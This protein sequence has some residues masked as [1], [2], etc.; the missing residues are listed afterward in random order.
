MGDT[1]LREVSIHKVPQQEVEELHLV[2]PARVLVLH[3]TLL[4]L[5]QAIPDLHLELMAPFLGFHGSL[6]I[7]SYSTHHLMVTFMGLGHIDPISRPG[8][9]LSKGGAGV[10][11]RL[12]VFCVPKTE[13][14]VQSWII[15]NL[16]CR[17][18]G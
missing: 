12:C 10:I 6:R 7:L 18:H 15:E 17:G 1:G 9:A 5:P 14:A 11:F 16:S 3:P 8:G 2:C 4:T 13:K